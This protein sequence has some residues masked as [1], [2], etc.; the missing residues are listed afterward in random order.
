MDAKYLRSKSKLAIAELGLENSKLKLHIE[1]Q[2]KELTLLREQRKEE[3][4]MR[5]LAAKI[6]KGEIVI[7]PDALV[8][9]DTAESIEQGLK[10][11]LEQ[12]KYAELGRMAIEAIEKDKEYFDCEFRVMFG[13]CISSP[14]CKWFKVCQKRA[15]LLVKGV[16]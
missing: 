9:R 15:E 4:K 2:E 6:K 5:L 3:I 10:E 8:F 13:D 14:G 7:P 16:E 1:Q 11:E 12:I